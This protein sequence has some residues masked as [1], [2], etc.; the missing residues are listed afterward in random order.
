MPGALYIVATPIGNLEDVTQR[1]LRV[2]GEVAVIACEDT[3][4][5]R[6]LLG[7]YGIN[8]PLISYYRE[9]EAERTG[10]LL[11]RLTAGE[12][13]ALISDAGTPL[14]SDPG[15]KLVER[16][17]A[18]GVRL[19]PV[20]GP[21]API[22]ALMAAGLAGS[23]RVAFAGFLPPRPGERRRYLAE[24]AV[25]AG[26]LILFEAPHRLLAA[27]AD[28]EAVWGGQRPL[29]VARELTKLHE[30]F[31]RGTIASARDHFAAHP[32]RGEF[33][34]VAGPPVAAPPQSEPPPADRAARKQWAR[35]HGVSR[36]EAYRRLQAGYTRER[37][38]R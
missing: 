4:R 35:A 21:S 29:V 33:T 26:G 36:S 15:G 30:E 16:A 8:T 34:L 38:G 18:A 25:W 10:E 5:S 7:H 13:V 3:R 28:M 22:T 32:P 37:D 6:K 1:A 2:L 20:P 19:I 23:E 14:I 9:N 27:L 31:L 11:R 12:D 17:L 24:L